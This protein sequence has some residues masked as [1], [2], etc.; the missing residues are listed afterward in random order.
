MKPL[1]RYIQALMVAMIGMVGLQTGLGQNRSL[2]IDGG[3]LIDGTGR[4]PLQNA[5]IV[6]EKNRITA[7]GEKG[8]VTVPQGAQ[9][10]QAAGK[11]IMP[12]FSDMHVH[13]AEWMPEMFLHWGITSAI[14]LASGDWNLAQRDLI[15]DGRM[16]G[17]RIFPT[18]PQVQVGR[19]LWDYPL[20]PPV[21]TAEMA[22]R[23]VHDVGPGREKYNLTKTYTELTFDQLQA[24]TEES[25]KMGRN[26]ISHLGSLDARQAAE[27]GVD[28]IA[29]TSGVALATI[30]D[31]VK[32]D[33]LRTF[34]RMGIAV[35]FPLYLMYHAYMVP[36]KVDELIKLL[37]QKNVRIEAELVNISGRWDPKRKEVWLAEDRRFFQDPNVQ[38]VNEEQRDRFFF[39]DALNKMDSQQK[40]LVGRGFENLKTF[41]RKFV[42][43]GGKVM[44]GCDTAS[45]VLSGI[46]IHRELEML[47]EAG[48]TPMQA[49]Q[50]AT[51]NNFEFVQEKDLGT[52][53][54]GKLADLII[55]KE[56]PLADIKNTRTIDT[57]IKDGNVQDTAFH[58]DFVNPLPHP[59]SSGHL[60]IVNPQPSIRVMYP[61][62]TKELNKNLTLTIEGTNLIE[63]ST[64]EFDGVD[65]PATPVK[66][67][68]DR[69]MVFNPVYTQL[70][71]AVPARL[72]N[73]YG[74]YKVVVKIPKP[75]GYSNTVVLGTSNVLNF[76][77]AR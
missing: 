11:F 37:V 24:I 22:R 44:A 59:T 13:W 62:S 5:V 39:Y 3:T 57:V 73:R 1:R 27:A 51:K 77:I 6:I 38:Y 16:K 40:A 23:V 9:V 28:G 8:K 31:P 58:A 72:L 69:E 65:L 50:A 21:D 30:E 45:F 14:D 63:G 42:Q 52:I 66:S 47:V 29:H 18:A 12:G 67:T 10:I 70:T 49:I 55:V 54:Q 74:D 76:F 71:V 56:D 36:A 25:H 33:E 53:E 68:M 4:A 19:L 61:M 35:D 20:A 46:C 75:Y 17:P 41:I 34:A 26:V 2:V 60:S 64:V 7:V 43:A 15:A 32:A 48:L